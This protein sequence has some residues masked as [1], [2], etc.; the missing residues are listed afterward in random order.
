MNQNPNDPIFVISG[1]ARWTK[2]GPANEHISVLVQTADDDSAI[3]K[4]LTALSEEGYAGA[5]LDKIGILNGAPEDEPFKS[6]F[7]D[8]LKGNVAIIR[9]RT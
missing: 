7:G 5:E 6:A 3:R 4:T 2:G 1:R 8:A 9:A